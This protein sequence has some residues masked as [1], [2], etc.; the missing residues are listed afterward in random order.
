MALLHSCYSLTSGQA[1]SCLAPDAWMITTGAITESLIRVALPLNVSTIS[2]LLFVCF[3]VLILQRYHYFECNRLALL[4][5]RSAL[6]APGTMMGKEDR[7]LVDHS[8]IYD[9]TFSIDKNGKLHGE[10][11]A[12]MQWVKPVKNTNAIANN[13]E[14]NHDSDNASVHS[15]S[16]SLPASS[17]CAPGMIYAGEIPTRQESI[18]IDDDSSNRGMTGIE[19]HRYSGIFMTDANHTFSADV[20]HFPNIDADGSI[21]QIVNDIELDP[22][23]PINGYPYTNEGIL[24]NDNDSSYET[25]NSNAASSFISYNSGS[26]QVSRRNSNSSLFDLPRP[27]TPRDSLFM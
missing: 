7:V 27:S 5:T 8:S 26:H 13:T 22:T 12:T 9:L 17:P 11:H 21:I 10:E 2:L 3:P 4:P 20:S 23:P 1:S 15:H 6:I 25:V 18:P 14:S 16:H 19:Q 24:D